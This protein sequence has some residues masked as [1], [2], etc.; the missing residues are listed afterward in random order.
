MGFFVRDDAAL[1]FLAAAACFVDTGRY[2]ASDRESTIQ[3]ANLSLLAGGF[4]R[5]I[6]IILFHF[7]QFLHK[8]FT[9]NLGF[10]LMIERA[11]SINDFAHIR[12][13]YLFLLRSDFPCG[14]GSRCLWFLSVFLLAFLEGK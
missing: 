5:I 8:V 6:T 7:V 2:D 9:R 11:W 1:G 14:W 13:A 12:S 10:L 4:I 3:R